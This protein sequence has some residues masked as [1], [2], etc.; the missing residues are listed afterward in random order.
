MVSNTNKD[1]F[2]K[3]PHDHFLNLGFYITMSNE[4]IA[5]LGVILNLENPNFP[6][7]CSIVETIGECN[8]Y[9]EYVNVVE[10]EEITNLFKDKIWDV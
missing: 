4:R 1:F 8:I 10:I 6:H 9:E 7:N 2:T 5:Y 3:L